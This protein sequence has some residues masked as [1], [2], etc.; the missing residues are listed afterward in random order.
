MCVIFDF[1][2]T[3]SAMIECAPTPY[4]AIGSIVAASSGV[5]VPTKLGHVQPAPG[6]SRAPPSLPT[7]PLKSAL[8]SDIIAAEML[9]ARKAAEQGKDYTSQFL[10]NGYYHV[11]YVMY[12]FSNIHV[13][14]A[15]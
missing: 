15:I 3:A 9:R 1:M 10:P 7:E 6:G 14:S 8:H 5:Q 12:H 2:C 13:F 11:S 4:G